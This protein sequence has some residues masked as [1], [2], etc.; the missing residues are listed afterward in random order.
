MMC[1]QGH[2]IIALRAS[3]YGACLSVQ[4]GWLRALI[5]KYHFTLVLKILA[6]AVN[7]SLAAHQAF[8]QSS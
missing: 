8:L 5:G 4:L 3:D 6:N 1:R 7:E 2:R